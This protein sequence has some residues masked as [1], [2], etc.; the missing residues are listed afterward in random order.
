MVLNLFMYVPVQSCSGWSKVPYFPLN[1]TGFYLEEASS[2][3]QSTDT[4]SVRVTLCNMGGTLQ[5]VI[6]KWATVESE[7][8]PGKASW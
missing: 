4:D 3:V 6:T 1:E 5:S 2:P 8:A 7:L